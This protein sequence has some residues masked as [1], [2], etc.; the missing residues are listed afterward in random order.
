MGNAGV[1]GDL[2][3]SDYIF[4]VQGLRLYYVAAGEIAP[5]Q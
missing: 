1:S 2:R 5:G 4:D 3:C